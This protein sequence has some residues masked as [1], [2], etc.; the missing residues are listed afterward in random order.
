MA[1][2]RIGSLGWAY[3]AAATSSRDEVGDEAN[4]R[5]ADRLTSVMG[6]TLAGIKRMGITFLTHQVLGL[7]D[8]RYYYNASLVGRGRNPD[9]LG[10][11]CQGLMYTYLVRSAVWARVVGKMRA[12]NAVFAYILALAATSLAYTAGRAAALRSFVAFIGVIDQLSTR[13]RSGITAP[14]V[15][16][17]IL[18]EVAVAARVISRP[19]DSLAGMVGFARRTPLDVRPKLAMCDDVAAEIAAPTYALAREQLRGSL[20]A[21]GV[22]LVQEGRPD[23]SRYY[24]NAYLLPVS[25]GVPPEIVDAAMPIYDLHRAFRTPAGRT[26]EAQWMATDAGLVTYSGPMGSETYRPLAVRDTIVLEG[27]HGRVVEYVRQASAEVDTDPSTV[28]ATLYYPLAAY[29]SRATYCAERD[30]AEAPEGFVSSLVVHAGVAGMRTS[31]FSSDVLSLAPV[32][33][34][35]AYEIPYAEFAVALARVRAIEVTRGRDIV[36]TVSVLWAQHPQRDVIV[37]LVLR[38]LSAQLGLPVSVDL[39]ASNPMYSAVFDGGPDPTLEF[40]PQTAHVF[41]SPIVPGGSMP[42]RTRA[43]EISSVVNRVQGALRYFDVPDDIIGYFEEFVGLSAP[44]EPLVPWDVERVRERMTRPAQLA[45]IEAAL[46][47]WFK[48]SDRTRNTTRSFLK[49]EAYSGAKP[50]RTIAT[51]DIDANIGILRYVLP[52]MDHYKTQPWYMFGLDPAEQGARVAEYVEWCSREGVYILDLDYTYFD[53]SQS[54][55]HRQLEYASIYAAFEGPDA[56]LA[57]RF[58]QAWT[59][60]TT[61]YPLGTKA[62]VGQTRRS[63]DADTSRGNTFV[64]VAMVYA[65]RRRSGLSKE[66]AYERIGLFGGDDGV[67]TAGHA[68]IIR[69]PQHGPLLQ[70]GVRGASVLAQLAS[71]LGMQLK[72]TSHRPEEPTTML[73]RVYYDPLRTTASVADPRRSLFKLGMVITSSPDDVA[74]GALDRAEGILVTDPNTPILG[75]WARAVK[76]RVQGVQPLPGRVNVGYSARQILDGAAPFIY[77][78]ESDRGLVY[79]VCADLVNAGYGTSVTPADLLV[80]DGVFDDIRAGRR[81]FEDGIPALVPETCAPAAKIAAVREDGLVGPLPGPVP[82]IPRVRM[83]PVF[84]PWRVLGRIGWVPDPADTVNE[85]DVVDAGE[86]PHG[87]CLV[88][89]A[90]VEMMRARLARILSRRQ[91]SGIAVPGGRDVLSVQMASGEW[92]SVRNTWV[93]SPADRST[94]VAVLRGYTYSPTELEWGGD[95]QAVPGDLGGSAEAIGAANAAPI[96]PAAEPSG[97][98]MAPTLQLTRRERRSR[99]NRRDGMSDL[100]SPSPVTRGTAAALEAVARL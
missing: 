98:A 74:A 67:T 18:N 29:R 84:T 82:E 77:P 35:S 83:V 91:V 17:A 63:G 89:G 76:A 86:V 97:S 96:A 73:G 28:R 70:R 46:K 15:R 34:S 92:I 41:H 80:L 51:Q 6:G 7:P 33:S 1:L 94:G 85:F 72:I 60:S 79:Q 25:V 45:L 100:T 61:V 57:L 31:T 12:R 37:T 88:P 10:G 90:T 64:S 8:N 38:F 30:A 39:R 5:F 42:M 87:W 78:P 16:G 43:N 20:G 62:S 71:E 69:G 68:G 93:N 22:T 14:T 26:A 19:L 99:R 40:A 23:R 13:D 75:A 3:L 27:T 49:P 4:S 53:G 48:F 11:A 24:R 65:A 50:P 66:E 47:A 54:H 2:P 59:H 55:I 44:A 58:M 21:R 81:D 32:S 36:P 56:A 9:L 95:A 52:L